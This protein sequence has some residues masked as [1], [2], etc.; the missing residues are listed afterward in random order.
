MV[1]VFYLKN[2]AWEIDF[3]VNDLFAPVGYDVVFFN[4]TTPMLVDSD[5][6]GNCILVVNDSY[7]FEKIEKM[8]KQMKPLAL[9]HLSDETGSKA[10]WLVL[11]KHVKYYVKQYNHRNYRRDLYPNIVQLPCA[12]APTSFTGHA[13]YVGSSG[14]APHIHPSFRNSIDPINDGFIKS[15]RNRSMD[16]AF[17]GTIKADRYEMTE[18]FRAAFPNGKSITGNNN[19]DATKQVVKPCDMLDIYRDAVFCP[20]GRGNVTL[21]CSRIYEAILCGAIP[22]VVAEDVEID[23]TFWFDGHVPIFVRASSWNAAIARCKYLMA[24]P[25]DLQTIQ[26]KNL[27]WWKRLINGYRTMLRTIKMV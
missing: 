13:M 18:R 7:S 10:D 26:T 8:V 15:V 21:D 6:I 25:D 24:N 16:W 9:F 17:I 12:Y 23:S 11:S 20:V 3:L 4:E 5:D 2:S 14:T 22:V 1:R 27:E 19:W